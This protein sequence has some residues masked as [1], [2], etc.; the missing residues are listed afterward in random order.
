[1]FQ[2]RK[3]FRLKEL[4]GAEVIN[5]NCQCP[6]QTVVQKDK[7]NQSVLDVKCQRDE[8]QDFIY[9][10]NREKNN[11]KVFSV[12]ILIFEKLKTILNKQCNLEKT[13]T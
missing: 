3:Q 1:M 5:H 2:M 13:D 6:L 10:Y 12:Y 11:F 4:G 8:L 9:I 7:G